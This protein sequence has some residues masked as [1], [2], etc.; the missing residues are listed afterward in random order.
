MITK[1]KMWYAQH[2][3]YK[4]TV[5]ELNSLTRHQLYDLGFAPE[6]IPA[7]AAEAAYGRRK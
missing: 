4:Q 1:I 7:V 6:M 3:A 2:K 5:K